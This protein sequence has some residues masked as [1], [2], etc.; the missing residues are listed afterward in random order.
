MR[1]ARRLFVVPLADND[2]G[3]STI[4][5]ALVSQ[6]LG[7][8][9]QLQKKGARALVSPWGRSIDAYVFGRSYQEVEKGAYG[10]VEAALNANDADWRK[11]ELVIM[12]SHVAAGDHGDIEQMIDAA[13]SAGFDVICATI[14][15]T[16]G[17]GDNRG[18]FPDIWRMGWDER[19]TIPNPWNDN[20]EGQLEAL[21]RDLWTWICR[22]LAS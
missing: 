2:H 21:G 1:I 15:F 5:R 19:W 3:K 20:P 7:R 22:A 9:M 18:Q 17:D 6:G 12:P 4:I 14:L 16:W 8:A 10:S 13:H 11:R